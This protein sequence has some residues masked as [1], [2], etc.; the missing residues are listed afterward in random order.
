MIRV[1][2]VIAGLKIRSPLSRPFI[3][4]YGSIPAGPSCSECRPPVP[5]VLPLLSIVVKNLSL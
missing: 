1:K 2:C 5:G 3:L 4:S